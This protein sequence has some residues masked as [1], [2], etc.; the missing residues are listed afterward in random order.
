MA[1]SSFPWENIDTTETQYSQLFRNLNSGVNGTPATDEL[2]VVA[3]FAGLTVDVEPGQAM[4]L[5]HYYI[6]TV[7]KT[8]TLDTADAV[9]DRIDTIV[10]RLDDVANSITAVVVT[11]TPDAS[12]VAPTLTQTQPYGVFEF[13]LADVLVEAAAG[14]PGTITDRRAFMG[15]RFGVWTTANRPDPGTGVAFGYNTSLGVTEFYDGTGWRLIGV[16]ADATTP[17]YRYVDTVYFTSSGEFEKAD[18]PWLRAI[19]VRCQ[20]GGGGGGGVPITATGGAAAGGGGGGGYA[21]SFITDIAGLDA[22][23]TVTRGGGGAGGAAGNNN[24]SSGI[25]SSFGGLVIGGPG[26][27]GQGM[28]L[29]TGNNNAFRG[30][31][32]GATG[33]I[34]IE[35]GQGFAGIVYGGLPHSYGVGGSSFLGHGG[36]VD[37]SAFDR[38]GLPG[39]GI[40]AGGSGAFGRAGGSAR[41][42]GSGANGIV[43]VDLFA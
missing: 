31:G 28:A 21:E 39:R 7:A 32:G 20:G 24:G 2:E 41:A 29:T 23:V 5:G 9:L 34:A 30:G 12:P 16:D 43:I 14:V 35:G 10:L 26:G 42:G 40:G 13:P 4:V 8:L 22:S 15:E 18:F 19:R 25:A 11:G 38:D 17:A 6:N 27:F 1:E 37:Q 33:E 36:T 3:G